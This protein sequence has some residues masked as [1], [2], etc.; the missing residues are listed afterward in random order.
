MILALPLFV[1]DVVESL[2]SSKG[3]YSKGEEFVR[4]VGPLS[5]KVM[6]LVVPWWKLCPYEVADRFR[7]VLPPLV[8]FVALLLW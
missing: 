7:R 3:R 8:P 1:F 6:A 5:L 2:Q 4:E